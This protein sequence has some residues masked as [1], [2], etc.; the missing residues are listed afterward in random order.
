MEMSQILTY[1][2]ACQEAMTHSL[3]QLV[4]LDSPTT[5]RAAVNSV[6]DYLTQAFGALDVHIE[7]VPQTAYGDHLRLTWGHGTRQVLLLGH[8]DTVWPV[9][10]T[11][12]RPF[13]VSTDQASGILKAT[14]P[15]AFDM[16]GGLVIALYAITALRDLRLEPDLRLVLLLNSDEEVGS[17][18]SR[19]LI[20][21]E[22]R[23]SDAVLVLEPSREGALVTW[24]KGVGRFKLDIQGVASHSGAAH[25]RGV[26]ALEEMAHQIL[27]LESMTDYR[28]GT[29]VNVGVVQ[30]GS[31]V[32]IRPATAHAEIDLR[33]ATQAEG[34]RVTEAIQNLQPVNPR[35]TLKVTGGMNR[36]PWETSPAGEALFE[37]ARRVGEALGMDL[38]QAGTGGG[39]DG[40]FT[41]ALGTAT[42]DGM[43]IVGDDAHALTEWVDLRSLPRRAAL[44]TELLL[45]LSK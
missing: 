42:L 17:P 6:V 13:Q 43:G 41:A 16:K 8:M 14:G 30:G 1:L 35:A 24:R 11:E 27:L 19:P 9:G 32:N 2:S 34:Q 44:L 26:S 36:P 28:R 7:R 37:R 20:E 12:T 4:R 40:N 31:R 45:D 10:E 23:R 21:Q 5:D 39:S 3:E 38:W 18:T 33:V 22:G 15:G 25:E 29:T